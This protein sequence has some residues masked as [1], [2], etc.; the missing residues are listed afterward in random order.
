MASLDPFLMLPLMVG[1]VIMV[2]YDCRQLW[3]VFVKSVQFGF[4]RPTV[5]TNTVYARITMWYRNVLLRQL[6]NRD[7]QEPRGNGAERL[8]HRL[9]GSRCGAAR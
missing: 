1:K 6:G 7:A 3:T 5:Q 4:P 2:G 8:A 9:G